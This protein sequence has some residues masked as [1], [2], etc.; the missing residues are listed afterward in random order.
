M[1]MDWNT[2]YQ[3]KL[4]YRYNAFLIKILAEYFKEIAKLQ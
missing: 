3:Y 2:Y 4:I 1:F